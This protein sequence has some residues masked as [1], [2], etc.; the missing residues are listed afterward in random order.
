[1]V[2]GFFLILG[3]PATLF[4]TGQYLFYQ[5][6]HDILTSFFRLF[7]KY[8]AILSQKNLTRGYLML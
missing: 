2:S 5:F 3:L 1:M 8:N 6:S 7:V 4:V